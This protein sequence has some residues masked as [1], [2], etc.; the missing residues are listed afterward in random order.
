MSKDFLI[1]SG[2]KD[3][4][5]FNAYVEHQY[6]NKIIDYFKQNGFDLVKTPLVEF[7]N[8]Q[9]KNNFFIQNK[10]PEEELQIRNDITPQ[11]IRVASS[12]FKNRKMPLKL[13]Y[14]GEVVRKNGSMLRPERQF[15]QVGAETIGSN[16]IE[17]DIEIIN[18]A[19]KSLSIIGIKNMTIE[20]SSRIFLDK[21]FN[22]IKN[23]KN[24]SNLYK[25]ISKKDLDS[26][27]RLVDNQNKELVKNIFLCTGSFKRVNLKLD[28][29]NVDEQTSEE[30][31]K[32]RKIASNLKFSHGDKL[33]IDFS[34]LDEKNYHNGIR[35]TFFAKNVRGEI[36]SGGRY[37]IKNNN[38]NTTATGF[39][40][41]MDSVIRASSFKNVS[42]K[43]LIPFDVSD[44][45]KNKLK[46]NGYTI[47]VIFEDFN[48]IKDK[49]KNY[50]CSY[51][52]DNE[53]VKSV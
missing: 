7:K 35:F 2:F 29:L 37:R 5:T 52:L 36:A 42:K 15:L 45:I 34:E 40:C 19:Y 22:K 21:L 30:I 27:M 17:A 1:P 28:L 10:K 4:V 53:K 3:E 14:Y 51:Y 16:E 32:I 46:K 11:I 6:K 25:F 12:R 9:N 24:I 20:L 41:Y 13:C 39:T 48:S 26:S 31:N 33:Y 18:I 50:G 44:S 38:L 23:K 49:A 43:I 8:K 47:F